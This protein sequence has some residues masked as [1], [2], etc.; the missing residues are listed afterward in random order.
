MGEIFRTVDLPLPSL[1]LIFFRG[2]HHITGAELQSSAKTKIGG[3]WEI[4]AN[5]P[6]CLEDTPLSNMG[7]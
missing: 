2:F 5:R 6:Q 1:F 4:I 7:C 3:G